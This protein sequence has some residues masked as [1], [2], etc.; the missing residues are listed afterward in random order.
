MESQYRR[1]RQQVGQNGRDLSSKE[2]S[3]SSP[4]QHSLVWTALEGASIWRTFETAL[5]CH[6]LIVKGILLVRTAAVTL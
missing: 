3:W 5:Q 1:S 2:L 6:M 4:W